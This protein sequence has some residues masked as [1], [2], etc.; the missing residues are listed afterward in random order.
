MVYVCFLFGVVIGILI[1]VMVVMRRSVGLSCVFR[2]GNVYCFLVFFVFV[3]VLVI[4]LG[5]LIRNC[6][7][8]VVWFV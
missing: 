6:V 1:V 8:V 4:V 5:E 7:I 3:W 2:M